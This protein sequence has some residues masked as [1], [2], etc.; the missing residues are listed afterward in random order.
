MFT[1]MN[2]ADLVN[3]ENVA[4]NNGLFVDIDPGKIIL[5]ENQRQSG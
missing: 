4:I 2:N 3:C 5:A 1:K